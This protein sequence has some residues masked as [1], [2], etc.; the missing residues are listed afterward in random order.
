MYLAAKFIPQKTVAQDLLEEGTV[1]T[2]LARTEDCRKT[3]RA[4]KNALEAHWEPFDL[5]T[6]GLGPAVIKGT[7]SLIDACLKEKMKA[8]KS[9]NSTDE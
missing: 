7:F 3:L 6:H 9:K 8:L 4:V 1:H 5:A 2:A